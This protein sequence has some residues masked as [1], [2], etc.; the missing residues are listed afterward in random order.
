MR[1]SPKGVSARGL[2][3]GLLL[4]VGLSIGLLSAS[5]GADLLN[6][7]PSDVPAREGHSLNVNSLLHR[8]SARSRKTGSG[9]ESHNVSKTFVDMT[10]AELATAVPELKHLK[11]AESQDPLPKILDRAGSAVAAFFDNFPDTAC[12]EQVTSTVHKASRAG[13]S[14]YDH[15]YRYV[16]L[17]EPGAVKGHLREYRAAAKGDIVQP[18]G[19]VTFG[20]VALSVNFY[21]DY[22]VDSRFH[23]LGR[24][25]IEKQDTYVVA[26]AQ[27]PAVARQTASVQFLDQ[28]GIVYLQGIAWIDPESFRIVHLRTDLEQPNLKVGLLKETMNV[29]YSEVSF[30]HRTETLWLPRE[31]TVTGR[32][33]EYLFQNLHRY[34]D[35]Q[36]FTVQ[37]EQKQKKP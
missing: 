5:Y 3:R 29:L 18:E 35:Y 16:A 36:L 30:A 17:A 23:Y 24:D 21:P 7:K 9:G 27:R 20:F 1:Q 2:V 6:F 15:K 28:S 13:V 8:H 4:G 34:S 10:P 32:L 19:I 25:V 22:Q 14:H 26:F 31:V 33:K 11:P 12:T 37:V